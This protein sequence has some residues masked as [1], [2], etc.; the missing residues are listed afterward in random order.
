LDQKYFRYAGNYPHDTYEVPVLEPHAGTRYLVLGVLAYGNDALRKQCCHWATSQCMMLIL[1]AWRV[2]YCARSH[3]T[4][5][6]LSRYEGM[7]HETNR[8]YL[9]LV[10]WY[11]NL[12]PVIG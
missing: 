10:P 9:Y 3:D 7:R 8:N 2:R 5:I 4:Y 1:V 11:W 6:N 12:V